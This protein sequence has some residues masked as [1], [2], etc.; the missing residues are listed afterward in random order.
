MG[1]GNGG[2]ND[3]SVVEQQVSNN[4]F[5]HDN[6]VAFILLCTSIY[7]VYKMNKLEDFGKVIKVVT[8]LM[9][10]TDKDII[11]KCR[12]IEAVDARWLAIRLMRD[13]GYTTRQIAPLFNR[14][15]RSVTHALLY[16]KERTREPYSA[17]GN[18]Y[19]VARQQV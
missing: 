4:L 2:Q 10:V 8:E 7:H 18:M 6:I 12:T 3:D 13:K 9:E 14:S 16:F 1:C 5:S 19:A 11:G 17:L 15:K